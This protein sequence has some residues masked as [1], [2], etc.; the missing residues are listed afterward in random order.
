MNTSPRRLG[1]ALLLVG[2][3]AAACAP[4]DPPPDT[5]E[6]AAPGLPEGHPAIGAMGA[7]GT[8]LTGV[9]KES[10]DGGGYTYALL[11]TGDRELWVAGP[12][13]SLTPGEAVALPDTMN[14]GAFEVAS[15]GRTFEEL[16]FTGAFSTQA[17]ADVAAMEFEGKVLEKIDAGGYT[18]LHVAAGEADIWLAA[19]EA[20]VAEGDMVA[21][22]G[23]MLMADFHSN[24]LNRDFAAIYFVERVSRVAPGA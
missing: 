1:G 14:M 17:P 13:T 21:W 5:Q 23:G 18:Y 12:Q 9:V 8:V 16:Y 11:D 24:A 4:G 7:P 2:L 6:A 15:L 20:D 19:G 10:L 22:N 3:L